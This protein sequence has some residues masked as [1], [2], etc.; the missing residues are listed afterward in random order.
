MSITRLFDIAHNS[1]KK[2]PK[3]DVLATKYDGKWEKIST[4]QFVD[5]GDKFSRGLLKSGITK[6]DKIGLVSTN[7]RTEW[8]IADLGISQIGAISVPVYPTISEE[9]YVYIFNNAELKYCF[10]SDKDLYE[11]LLRVKEQ[12]PSLVG[13][14]TFDEV[15][16]AANWTEILS[17]GEDKSNQYEVED[18]RDL[19]NEDDIATIIYTSGTT[20]RPKGVMLSHKNIISNMFAVDSRIPKKKIDYKEIKTLSFLPI[21]HVFERLVYLYYLYSGFSIYFAE[22]IDKIGDNMKEVKPH[23]MSVVPRL[24]E[25]VYDKIYNKGISAG[26]L[27]KMIF[28]WA[29]GTIKDYELGTPKNF[30]QRIA[31]RL[32]FSK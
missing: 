1:L 12:V 5:L 7:N 4:K 22:S 20:G 30:K 13:I 10:V 31:D 14:F 24:L 29:L 26:G 27:K 11:K 18:L 17:L 32:V 15:K 19:V 21:C 3:D 9:D 23:Y 25:K 8:C 16:G 28:L 2:F 6:D